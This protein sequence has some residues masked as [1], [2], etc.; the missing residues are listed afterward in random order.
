MTTVGFSHAVALPVD[1]ETAFWDLLDPG[2]VPEYDPDFRSWEPR[3]WPPVVGTLVDFEARY[4]RVWAKGTS[5]FEVVDPPHVAELRL[6]KPPTPV[7][8]RLVWSFAPTDEGCVF[9][10]RFEASAPPGLGWL[11]RRVLGLATDGMADKLDRLPA[12][13]AP[14]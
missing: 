10:Y 7:R 3:A 12:R 2:H 9:T 6:V 8:S 5:R 1:A 11:A 13:F 14:A 4:G